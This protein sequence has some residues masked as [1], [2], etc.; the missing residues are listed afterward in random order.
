MYKEVELKNKLSCILVQFV[1]SHWLVSMCHVL[2][3]YCTTVL[4]GSVCPASPSPGA[5]YRR[6][7][8]S[9]VL[10][11][12]VLYST[13]LHITTMQCTSLYHTSVH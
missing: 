10:Y 13:V 2:L 6:A 11:C 9:P 12:T 5:K 7:V 4:L 8:H 1:A 3:Y